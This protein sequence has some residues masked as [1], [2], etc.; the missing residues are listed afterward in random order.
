MSVVVWSEVVCVCGVDVLL[1]PDI[2]WLWSVDVV[3]VR[4]I[5]VYSIEDV[6]RVLVRYGWLSSDL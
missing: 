5:H 2:V 1:W 6:D 4:Q 3:R